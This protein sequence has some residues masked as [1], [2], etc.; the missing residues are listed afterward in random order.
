M[1]DPYRT[2]RKTKKE[3]GSG[4]ELRGLGERGQGRPTVLLL[5]RVEEVLET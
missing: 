3:G 4:D 5:L 2:E 1:A